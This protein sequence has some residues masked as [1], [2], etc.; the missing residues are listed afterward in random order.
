MIVHQINLN[1]AKLA[2]DH[3]CQKMLEDRVSLYLLQEPYYYKS[4]LIG[5]PRGYVAFGEK[6]SRAII[7]AHESLNLI[8]VNEFSSKDMTV[9][10]FETES[11]KRFYISM[12]LDIH[13]EPVSS[14]M[15]TFADFLAES[16]GNAI[17]GIDSNAH[18][19]F[20]NSEDT[21]SRGQKLEEFILTY[22]MYVLNEG[23]S[24][25]FRTSRF[26]TIID[27]TLAL[28][29]KDDIHSWNV[30]EKYFF[31]DHQMIEFKVEGK[32]PKPKKVSQINWNLFSK[33]AE[34][35]R[36]NYCTWST[37]TIDAEAE[38]IEFL[39]KEALNKSTFLKPLKKK[40]L[41][42]FTADLQKEKKVVL[43]LV[44]KYRTNPTAENERNLKSANKTYF[45]KVRKA[46]RKS[47]KEFCD[48][49]CSPESMAKLEKVMKAE[50]RK[51]LGML[52]YS[53][54]D[55]TRTPNE[56]IEL[57]MS[58]FFPGSQPLPIDEVEVENF[59]TDSKILY[60]LSFDSFI[61]EGKVKKAFY[62]FGPD[63]SPGLDG[64]TPRALQALG[65]LA[66]IRITILFK[67]CIEI[68]YTP[69]R[70]RC[71]K[72]VFMAKPN[73]ESYS[74]V[75]SFRPLT[76]SS[77]LLKALERLVIWELEEK[78]F[79]IRPVSSNQHA[80]RKGFS[81]DTALSS[82]VDK[83]ESS[84]T[85]G[86]CTL[87]V[88][89]DIEGAFNSVSSKSALQAM[90]DFNLP[91]NIVEWYKQFHTNRY[92]V[93][94]ALGI[95]SK[96]KLL[97]GISQGGVA[98]PCI[99][100]LVFDSFL[101]LF[102]GPVKATG[103]ADDGA[104]YLHGFDPPTMVDL[105]ESALKLA[106]EWG[107]RHGLTMN[108]AKTT[109]MF[110][111]RKNKF[112]M[113]RKVKMSG[114]ELEYS[115]TC[116]YLGI[117]LD[118]R[119][120]YKV[121]IEQK[122]KSARKHILKIR[123]A[124]GTLWG[125]NARALRWS[126]QTIILSSICYGSVVWARACS[127]SV[128]RQKLAKIN[129]LMS[130][131]MMPTRK[132]TPTAGLEVILNMPP[133]DL[134]VEET[135]L[136]AMLRVLPSSQ[137]SWDGIGKSGTGHL[138]WGSRRLDELGIKPN[139][140][141]STSSI[142]VS[143]NFQIDLGSFNSGL[144]LTDSSTVCYTDGSRTLEGTGYGLGIS[145]QDFMIVSENGNLGK[146]TSVFQAEVFAIHR[147][148]D[149]LLE[150]SSKDV[151]IFSDSQSALLALESVK[152]KSKV[153]ENCLVKLNQLSQISR[154][155]LK[156]VKAHDDHPGNEFADSEA[157]LGTVNSKN[158]VKIFEPVSLAKVKITKA[159]I[160]S[161]NRRWK[162]S[163]EYRQTKI[164]FPSVDPKKSK[165]FLNLSRSELGI[166][167]QFIT[168]HNRLNRHESLMSADRDPTCRLCL[169]AEET[170]WHLMCDCPALWKVRAEIFGVHFMDQNPKW[171]PNQFISMA[172][173]AKL[174]EL[175]SASSA[176]NVLDA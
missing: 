150:S 80:F 49:I 160:S 19:S 96:R 48:S 41:K 55:F 162:S 69:E 2:N 131:T 125:P 37:N 94:D 59:N 53:N 153:V 7:I 158:L 95:K 82:L 140:L 146:N 74:K 27:I 11:I 68:G 122:V 54:G 83:I 24:A 77:F 75:G 56:A 161:W 148:C 159:M 29:A 134:K 71:S 17:F 116:K 101:E 66:I 36:P 91:S 33:L 123:S 31:S 84:I 147:A 51:N 26:A 128:T 85:R 79:K 163:T 142:S 119:L 58:T 38:K 16:N 152:I 137:S 5:I 118:T 102:K 1:K 78:T 168:G 167:V 22:N 28:G 89:C 165:Y 65:T 50:P 154:V 164:W 64:I 34:K 149:K 130:C 171:T 32:L 87:V 136:K 39:L 86:S 10:L 73:K 104:L 98:S 132:G 21:N 110:F 166:V 172:H 44:H 90:I 8:Y 124:I 133:I 43:Q 175:N 105:M 144:P 117:T 35:Q 40:S 126:Y 99:W 121:H 139:N 15:I 45:K 174:I 120:R 42:W 62:S 155:Q 46:K 141:D 113:P 138:L 156:W 173:R 57:A 18:S 3:L 92:A 13:M 52:Q 114:V 109:A 25:T 93:V 170:S 103:Y 81:T 106:V 129:R 88:F 76:L 97:K 70:W 47:W 111:H 143:R 145:R 169:E 9:C 60:D 12:Y 108:P 176:P 135:A 30:S 23:E 61:T 4:K 72:V 67:V 63:K 115:E 157:K 107:T 127:D 112:R 14:N 6:D 151:T 100:N 20:W